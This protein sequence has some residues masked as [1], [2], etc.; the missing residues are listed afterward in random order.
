MTTSLRASALGVLGLWAAAA[1]AAAADD[2]YKGTLVCAFC[3]LEKAAAHSCQDVLLVE[4]PDGSTAEYYI[5]KNEVAE[6]AGE[7]CTLRVPAVITGTVSKGDDGTLWLT[8]TKI[9]RSDG[10]SR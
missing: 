6:K 10:G 9:V 5:T 7:V 4:Q 8:P 2:V 1:V 3:G